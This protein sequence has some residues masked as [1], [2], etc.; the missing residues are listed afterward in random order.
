MTK[1]YALAKR[2]IDYKNPF[3]EGWRKNIRRVLGDVPWYVHL[4]PNFTLP[5]P[6]MYSFE[7]N[8]GG[9]C[10]DNHSVYNVHS[11]VDIV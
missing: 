3:D 8:G 1:K 2:G 7:Y 10:E 9:C 6:P 4:L 11:G 5:A